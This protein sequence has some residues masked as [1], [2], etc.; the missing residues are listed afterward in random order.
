M[1]MI[2]LLEPLFGPSED[3]TKMKQDAGV[4]NAIGNVQ[5]ILLGMGIETDAGFDADANKDINM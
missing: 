3:L 4:Q 5:R 1:D 2:G